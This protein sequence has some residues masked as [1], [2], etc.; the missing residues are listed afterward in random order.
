MLQGKLIRNQNELYEMKK[1]IIIFLFSFSLQA[2]G[3]EKETYWEIENIYRE[4]KKPFI[5]LTGFYM[6]EIY[7]NNFH[8]VKRNDSL[9]FELPEKFVLD[10]NNFKSLRQL[11]ITN[12]DYYEMYDY[13]FNRDNFIIKFKDNAT[14][15]ESKNTIIDFK[16]I[17]KEQF[18]KNVAEAISYQ[19]DI[20]KKINELKD[21]L[22]NN[23]PIVLDNV[24]KLSLKSTI[25]SNDKSDD[26]ELLIPN[27]VELRVSGDIKNEKFG[28]IKIGTIKDNSKIY[29]IK[30]S[31]EDYGL[32]QLTI[33]ISTDKSNFETEKYVSE[34]DAIVLVRKGN[35]NIIGYTIG[36]D[37]EN[38]KAK[39]VSFF[40]LKYF[41]VGNSQIF[42]HS[43]VLSSDMENNQNRESNKQHLKEMNKILNFNYLIS[44]NI[45]VKH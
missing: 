1:L 9:F 27:E 31:K 33:W 16:K 2:C 26:I 6:Q 7:D 29:D 21:E 12:R 17:S 19:K 23:P 11:N 25:I 35:N 5:G 28:S 34:N 18:E 24:K 41:K 14:S 10:L 37:F 13:I 40:T 22:K 45:T 38:E 42:I 36:Y 8:F 20:T 32:E 44:E 39:I 4:D 43:E 15:T 3:Q 30:H